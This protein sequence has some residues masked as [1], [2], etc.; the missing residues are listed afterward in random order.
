M[1]CMGFGLC[2]ML[3]ADSD[4]PQQ[5]ST[6]CSQIQMQIC[7]T[8]TPLPLSCLLLWRA[9]RLATDLLKRSNL[10]LRHKDDDSQRYARLLIEQ[11][12]MLPS[13]VQ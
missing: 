12:E 1:H 10:L 4:K 9:F 2:C 6:S 7:F 13:L 8:G 11:F 3:A 5:P